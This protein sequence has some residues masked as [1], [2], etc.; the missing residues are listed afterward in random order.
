MIEPS[1]TCRS[2]CAAHSPGG[3]RPFSLVARSGFLLEGGAAQRVELDL[4]GDGAHI[5]VGELAQ[6]S[7]LGVG[8]GRLGGAA[9]AQQIDLLDPALAQGLE[10][11]VGD[12]GRRPARPAERHRMRATS[13]ATLPTPTTAARSCGEVERASRDSRDGR[14]TRPRTR[15]RDG[16]PRGPRRECPCA[17]RSGR[18]SCRRSG[19][20]DAGGPATVRSL[21]NSTP[22]KNRKR[23]WAATLSKAAVTDLIFW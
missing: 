2:A 3:S 21:P 23:G 12:V 8:E 16:C 22:P 15:W 14:C 20:S 4:L 6:L 7:D 10:G 1:S 9:P 11:V 18:P 13:T 19:D 5:G 17:G